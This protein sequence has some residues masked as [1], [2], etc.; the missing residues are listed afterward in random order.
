MVERQQ[1]VVRFWGVRG[2]YPTPGPETLRHGGN[3]A[4]I[5]VQAG[6]HIL[7]FDAG[8]GIIALGHHLLQKAEEE[9]LNLSL[10]ITHGHG[11]HLQGF[12]FFTP[13]FEQRTHLSCFGPR[14]T[15]QNI[16]QVLSTLMA[17][18]YFPV[19]ISKLPSQ[20]QFHTLSEEKCI[21]WC[22][23]ENFPRI[24]SVHEDMRNVEVCVR[25]NFTECH[26]L[27]GAVHYRVEYGGHSM[28]YAT[29]VEWKGDY[30][31]GFLSLAHGTDM[32]IHDAQYTNE[33]YQHTKEGFGHSTVAMATGAA[34]AAHAGELVLFH[35]EP[36]YTDIQLDAM[37][38][39]ARTQF[40]ATRSAYEGMEI[41]LLA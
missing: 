34:N 7:I 31:P 25:V 16:E 10:F 18:P 32:L 9:P 39:E 13:L 29:D 8:T 4:C 14:L 27:D 1:F 3:T 38:A 33:D 22:Y 36:L 40:A 12:P 15:D 19:E 6:K 24:V 28:V 41:D 5:E 23:G 11:D 2:S 30:D 37:E 20:R 21:I 26:P 17:P 35:H